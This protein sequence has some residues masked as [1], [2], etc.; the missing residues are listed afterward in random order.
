MFRTTSFIG[1]VGLSMAV[2]ITSISAQAN[3]PATNTINVGPGS[4]RSM[5][6]LDDVD[7]DGFKDLLVG[8]I[9]TT[10]SLPHAAIYS[11]ASSQVILSVTGTTGTTFGTV[12]A[13]VGDTDGDG[14]P[15]FAVHEEHDTLQV[16]SG[17]TGALLRSHTGSSIAKVDDIDG[18]G[19]IDYVIGDK[20][21]EVVELISGAT[22]AVLGSWSQDG[23][24]PA[25]A[26][27]ND[28]D[29]DGLADLAL[30]RPTANIAFLSPTFGEV[31]LVSSA[32]GTIIRT[33]SAPSGARFFGSTLCNFGD[34]DGDGVEDL[35]IGAPGDES[36]FNAGPGSAYVAS[37]AT[38]AILRNVTP[39]GATSGYGSTIAT[40]DFDLDGVD[41]IAVGNPLFN[42]FRGRA[43]VFSG[44]T[45]EERTALTTATPSVF[46]HL[47]EA[48]AA[49]DLNGDG[50]DELCISETSRTGVTPTEGLITIRS[51]PSPFAPSVLPMAMTT[52]LNA[53]AG[54]STSQEFGR[55][56]AALGDTDGDGVDDLAVGSTVPSGGVVEIRSGVDQSSLLT[57]NGSGLEF[58]AIIGAAGD[59]DGDGAADVAVA[60]P[61]ATSNSID[62]HSGANGALLATL[63]VTGDIIAFEHVENLGGVTASSFLV[64]DQRSSPSQQVFQLIAS[65]GSTLWSFALTTGSSFGNE[66]LV[67]PDRN[68][69]G[70]DDVVVATYGG[71]SNGVLLTLSGLDGSLLATLQLPFPIPSPFNQ[72]LITIEDRDGDGQE[73]YVFGAATFITDGPS[74][75]DFV[76][77]ATGTIIQRVVDPLGA[78]G[79]GRFIEK[80]QDIDGDG[81]SELAVSSNDHIDVISGADGSFMTAHSPGGASAM[82]RVNDV[83][84]DGIRDLAIGSSHRSSSGLVFNGALDV[85]SI[86]APAGNPMGGGM[87]VASGLLIAEAAGTVG[88]GRGG[89]Y[90]VLTAEGTAGG[91]DRTVTVSVGAPFAMRMREAPVSSGPRHFAIFGRIGVPAASE[92]IAIPSVGTLLFAPAPFAAPN[93]ALFTLAETYLS[94]TIGLVQATPGDWSMVSPGGIPVAV[95]ITFQGICDDPEPGKTSTTNAFVLRVM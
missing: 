13:G 51:A 20:L 93:A 92:A 83:N 68:G 66:W 36:P 8:I 90:A 47:G 73:D 53:I 60:V 34:L 87:P 27:V 14:V 50:I 86:A 81:F 11:G 62:V 6:I 42:L 22:G 5:A 41:D 33:I 72:P 71:G 82:V 46:P 67:V 24:G 59:F 32:T 55:S 76:S 39:V 17:A 49:G 43:Y 65:G 37:P 1:A 44:A 29:G 63:P 45:G 40:G 78:M 85:I 54:V 25:V 61:G 16:F 88:I 84:G 31:Q 12:V 18:D 21:A 77:S 95:D 57:I 3:W 79:F 56:L 74:R 7:G 30:G 28:L 64:V 75:I 48:L 94:P 52:T 9:G 38:G 10:T 2:L 35:A 4:I 19:R 70:T 23:H 89:P 69:D 58:G 80:I 91:V 26:A 15:D